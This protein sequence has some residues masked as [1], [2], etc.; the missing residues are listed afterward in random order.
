ML[1]R[2]IFPVSPRLHALNVGCK[3]SI[4][5]FCVCVVLYFL[6]VSSSSCLVA[7]DDG[8]DV[9]LSICKYI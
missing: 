7:V 4:S 9:A 2:A 8:P 1:Y 5:R 3:L 6:C